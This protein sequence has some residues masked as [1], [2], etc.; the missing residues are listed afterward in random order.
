VAQIDAVDVE[1]IDP[2]GRVELGGEPARGVVRE[3]RDDDGLG[4]GAQ[5]LDRGL[6]ADLDPRAGDQADAAA[7]V[8]GLV[9]LAPVELRARRAHLIVELVQLEEL[10]LAHVAQPRGLDPRRSGR[11]VAPRLGLGPHVL[12]AVVVDGSG[13]VELHPDRPRQRR[14]EDRIAPQRADPGPIEQR[15]IRAPHRALAFAQQRLAQRLPRV[16][17]RPRHPAGGAH[18][19]RAQLVRDAGELRQIVGDLLEHARRGLEPRGQVGVIRH[20]APP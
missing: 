18:Q 12:V 3:P 16:A 10:G 2:L 5:Q 9:A 14:A 15:L 20:R 4:A 6:V 17:I 7:E 11:L 19:P 8:R 13:A 1:A